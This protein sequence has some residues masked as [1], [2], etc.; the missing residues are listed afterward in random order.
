[1]KKLCAWCMVD[2]GDINI[3]NM[4]IEGF[5]GREVSHGICRSC[6]KHVCQE[7]TLRMEESLEHFDSQKT[8]N[9][10]ISHMPDTCWD[11][12]NGKSKI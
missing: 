2:M 5:N 10:N 4:K 3:G 11:N 12:S 6:A 8:K 7:M 1:M 9:C